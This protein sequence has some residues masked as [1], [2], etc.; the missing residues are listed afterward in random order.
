MTKIPGKVRTDIEPLRT[1]LPR[2]Q[3]RR[4]R[5]V[6]ILG[7]VLALAGAGLYMKTASYLPGE[8]ISQGRQIGQVAGLG[9]AAAGLLVGIFGC[10]KTARAETALLAQEPSEPSY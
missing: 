3:I 9:L 5:L 2:R 10:V 4:G 8:Q 1:G 7:T 6:A